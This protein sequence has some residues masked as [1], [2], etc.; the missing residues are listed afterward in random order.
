MSDYNGEAWGG[1]HLTF[2]GTQLQGVSTEEAIEK[3]KIYRRIQRRNTRQQLNYSLK[4]RYNMKVIL[5]EDVKG[6][7]K[8]MIW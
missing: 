1:G 8:K 7:G 2:A 4:E 5:K 6:L 3:L